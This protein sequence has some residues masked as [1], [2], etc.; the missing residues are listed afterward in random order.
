MSGMAPVT[1]A[2]ADDTRSAG[3]RTDRSRFI[4]NPPSKK[5]RSN[6]D[7]AMNGG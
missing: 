7:V 6:R 4:D 5:I 2:I 3:S 1:I